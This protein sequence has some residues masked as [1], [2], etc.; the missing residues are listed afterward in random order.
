MYK[1]SIQVHC[2]YLYV[3]YIECYLLTFSI[4]VNYDLQNCYNASVS[5]SD[6]FNL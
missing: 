2:I 5:F 3:A 4:S 1:F 6:N